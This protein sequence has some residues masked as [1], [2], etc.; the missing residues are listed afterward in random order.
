MKRNMNKLA[1]A[2]LVLAALCAA[3]GLL[4]WQQGRAAQ[5]DR[6]AAQATQIHM[7]DLPDIH[8]ISIVNGDNHLNFQLDSGVWYYAD[9]K[10]CPLR[11]SALSSLADEL[12]SLEATRQLE[13]PDDLASYGLTDPAIHYEITTQ[14]GNTASLLV[15]S[16]VVSSGSGDMEKPPTEYYACLGGG[17]QVYTIGP[18]L[19]DTSAKGLYDFIQT[20]SLPIISGAD[21][22]DITVTKDGI[23]SRFVKKTVDSQGNIAWYRN[24][25]DSEENRLDDNGQ[26]N[27]LADAVS[28]LTIR[29]CTNYNATEEELGSYGLGDPVMTVTWTANSA[30]GETTTTL[31]VGSQTPDSVTYYTR[32]ENSNA[33]NLIS[34]EQVDKVMNAAYPQ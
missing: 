27:I 19:A 24:S 1:A 8:K 28:G 4:S 14:D 18:S 23:T 31:L 2:V 26:L 34:M 9:D 7:T 15:G 29:S 21:I 10:D 22:Q 17:S 32:L 13:Q 12:S 33:V 6:A 3:Y 30:K 11:Q 5:A 20:E 25:A 16:Q